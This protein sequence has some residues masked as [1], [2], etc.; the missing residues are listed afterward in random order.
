MS[1]GETIAGMIPAAAQLPGDPVA[2]GFAAMI[3]IGFI[4]ALA[5][6]SVLVWWLSLRLKAMDRRDE[7]HGKTLKEISQTLKRIA[8]RDSA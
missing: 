4:V 7:D 8:D 1:P 3:G 5:A 2:R 6:V